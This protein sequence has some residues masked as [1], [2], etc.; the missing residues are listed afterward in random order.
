MLTLRNPSVMLLPLAFPVSLS[1]LRC[2]YILGIS[3][4]FQGCLLWQLARLGFTQLSLTGRS[5]IVLIC[6]AM[7]HR[8]LKSVQPSHPEWKSMKSWLQHQMQPVATLLNYASNR[9]RSCLSSAL[10]PRM[11]T[12]T[13]S[14][15]TWHWQQPAKASELQAF[16]WTLPG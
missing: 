5:F 1:H 11:R 15:K 12:V 4:L 13:L 3:F 14:F 7:L 2:L 10:A 8:T 6:F 16:L 9:L